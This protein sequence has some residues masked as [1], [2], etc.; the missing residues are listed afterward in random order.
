MSV[1]KNEKAA[2]IIAP[3]FRLANDVKITLKIAYRL[4]NHLQ[5]EYSLNN[6]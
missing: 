3:L 2:Q 5:I 4:A 1:I 6:C